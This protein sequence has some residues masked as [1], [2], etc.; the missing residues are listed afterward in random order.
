MPLARPTT[1]T[2]MPK[3]MTF[4]S[5]TPEAWKAMLGNPQDRAA[6]A[7]TL[8]ESVGGTVESFYW[9]FGEH[10]GVVIGELPDAASAGGLSVAISASGA[11]ANVTTHRLLDAG[12]RDAL[13]ENANTALGS[14]SPPTG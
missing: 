3:Y 1:E 9:V 5:Y 7:K 12:E 10:D 14:Y 6:A 2:A 4:F 13:I 8:Y 11:I